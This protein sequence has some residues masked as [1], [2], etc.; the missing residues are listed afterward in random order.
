ME[1]ERGANAIPLFSPPTP[2]LAVFPAHIFLPHPHTLN[3]VQQ[4]YV[5]CKQV[6]R[7]LVND[8]GKTN[9]NI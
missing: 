8:T 9:L 5:F 2:P 7:Y 3:A 6:K 1:G 4:I